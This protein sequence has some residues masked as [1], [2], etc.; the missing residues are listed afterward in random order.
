MNPRY[1]RV[2]VRAGGRC[3]YCH[4]PEAVFN[5]AFQVEHVYPQSRGGTDTEENLALSCSACNLY[6]GDAVSGWDEVTQSPAALFDPR[7]QSWDEHFQVDHERA[8]VMGLTAAG[9]VTVARL[10]MN[11]PRQTAARRRWIQLGLFP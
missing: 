5:F 11:T 10:Q 2:A 4:A 3:E 8:E 6:K 1:F 9:R 7:T